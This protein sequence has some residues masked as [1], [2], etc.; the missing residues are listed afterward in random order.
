MILSVQKKQ[1]RQ[2]HIQ[3]YECVR[4]GVCVWQAQ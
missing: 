4:E 2:R 3:V 1:M